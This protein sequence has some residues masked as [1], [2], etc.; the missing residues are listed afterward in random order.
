MVKFSVFFALGVWLLQQQAELPPFSWAWML[1]PL[2]LSAL[3]P[4]AMPWQRMLRHAAIA[5]LAFA[6]GFLYAA[7]FAQQRLAGQL[8]DEWQGADIEVTGVVAELPRQREGGLSFSFD[9]EQTLTP[10]ARVPA[11]VLLS[12]YDNDQ[13]LP[14]KA[15]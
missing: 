4:R 7:F 1:L 8:P 11:H 3:L 13:S 9:V 14:L 6:L 5:A 12:T 15:G 10:G 2:G